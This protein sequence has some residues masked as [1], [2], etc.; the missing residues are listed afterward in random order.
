VVVGDS[1]GAPDAVRDG[2]T[3]HVVDGE[4]AGA[5]AHRPVELLT[6]RGASRP[7]GGEGP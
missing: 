2:G 3:G 6:D 1:G 5:V 7:M 4:D